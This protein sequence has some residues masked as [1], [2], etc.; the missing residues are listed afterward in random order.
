[1]RRK[2]VRSKD[3][4]AIG[5]RTVGDGAESVIVVGGSLRAAADYLAFAEVLARAFTVHI[6]DRRGRGESGPQGEDY[7]IEKECED[8]LAVQ[9]HTGARLG[10]GHSYGGL[11]CLESARRSPAFDTLAVYEPGTWVEDAFPNAW[12]APCRERLAS[13]DARGAFACMVKGAGFAPAAMSIMPLWFVK[14]GLRFGIPRPRLEQMEALL[15]AN[16]V[17][18]EEVVRLAGDFDRFRSIQSRVL[19]LGG[20]KSPPAIVRRSLPMLRDA[21][22]S[23]A[24]EILDGLGHTAPDEDAPE[25]IGNRVIGWFQESR[26][27]PSLEAHT[28]ESAASTARQP[29]PSL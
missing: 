9:L 14:L 4:T 26:G 28:A 18:H 6:I 17:E 11:I 23:S 1:M 24:M 19:I 12:V 15:G 5:Y 27:L 21:I 7:S 16:L 29:K 13:G 8:L 20:T 25:I 22:T 2:T 10:F 3:G